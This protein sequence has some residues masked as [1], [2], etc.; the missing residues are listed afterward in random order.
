MK[1]LPRPDLKELSLQ[2]GQGGRR[3]RG[4]QAPCQSGCLKINKW[5]LRNQVR[6]QKCLKERDW[7]LSRG[8]QGGKFYQWCKALSQQSRGTNTLQQEGWG[9]IREKLTGSDSVVLKAKN[10]DSVSF[11]NGLKKAKLSVTLW[12]YQYKQGKIGNGMFPKIYI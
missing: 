10:E 6:T 9:W 8:F 2:T 3:P 12:K 4:I 1:R 5:C 11:I 7:S